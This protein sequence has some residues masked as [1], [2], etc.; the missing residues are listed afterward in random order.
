MHD[1]PI[2][3]AGVMAFLLWDCKFHLILRD[4]KP[5]I[6]NPNTWCPVT[7]GVEEGESFLD[8]MQ[9]ELLEEI[10]LIPK[11]LKTLGVSA[12]GNCFFFG[13]L[14]DREVARIVLGE[15]QKYDFFNFEQL[16]DLD[17]KGA[18]KIYLDRYSDIFHKMTLYP[19]YLP[20]GSDLGLAVWSEP[21]PE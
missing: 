15:G 20:K 1:K 11:Y 12:K 4:D 6:A 21:P 9:R 3:P 18:F 13:R 17:I 5:Q 2:Q 19:S 8:A 14:N 7:G 10:G 16:R